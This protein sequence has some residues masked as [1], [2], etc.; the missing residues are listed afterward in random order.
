MIFEVWPAYLANDVCITKQLADGHQ[1]CL[2]QLD[3]RMGLSVVAAGR[4][5]YATSS[6]L[7]SSRPFTRI[8]PHHIT[9]S[10][11]FYPSHGS[12]RYIQKED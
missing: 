4:G 3:I 8:V 9:R 7:L 6:T 12:T 5:I 2:T 11:N 1:G 10:L